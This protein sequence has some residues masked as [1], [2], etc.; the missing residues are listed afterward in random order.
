MEDKAG[1]SVFV[2]SH[3]GRVIVG[4]RA[5]TESY[6]P[7]GQ[8]LRDLLAV[9]NIRIDQA[10]VLRKELGKFTER[11]A[12]IR[13][14]FEKVKVIFLYIKYN[15]DFREKAQKAVCIFAGFGDKILRFP[16]PDISADCL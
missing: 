3:V 2:I 13:K 11:T 10:A 16:Y 9:G 6:H 4:I 12:D 1:V 5:G 15:S 14:I 8:P 7:A